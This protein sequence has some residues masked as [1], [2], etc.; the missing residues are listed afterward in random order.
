MNNPRLYCLNYNLGLKKI[1]CFFLGGPAQ[2]LQAYGVGPPS[3]LK[4]AS[5]QEIYFYYYLAYGIL[6]DITTGGPVVRCL[7]ERE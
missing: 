2:S 7:L 3:I 5:C 1:F 6:Y 4:P